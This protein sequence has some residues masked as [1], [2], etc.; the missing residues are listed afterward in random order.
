M[1]LKDN[2]L[3]T[4]GTTLHDLPEPLLRKVYFFHDLRLTCQT[5]HPGILAILD[6]MPRIFREAVKIR[7]EITYFV[8]C[9]DSVRQ[10]PVQLPARRVRTGTMCLLTNTQLTYYWSGDC[11]V[12]YQSYTALPP[13]N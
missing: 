5:N 2:L 9:Y 10:F 1:M 6:T 3:D 4:L 12:F 8:L 13:T 7:G 11:T